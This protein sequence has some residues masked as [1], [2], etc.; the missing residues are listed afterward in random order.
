MKNRDVKTNIFKKFK[1]EETA[2]AH[3]ILQSRESSGSIIL[4]P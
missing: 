1:L 3:A 4:E 2:E